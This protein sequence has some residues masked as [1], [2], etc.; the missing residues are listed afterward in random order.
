MSTYEELMNAAGRVSSYAFLEGHYNG[1]ATNSAAYLAQEAEYR[2]K[3]E[4]A[5]KSL[6]A[7]AWEVTA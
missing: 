1:L 3:K 5:L 7:L 4:E 6:V 2:E